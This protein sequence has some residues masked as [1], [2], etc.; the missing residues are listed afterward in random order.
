MEYVDV[1]DSSGHP[2]GSRKPKSEA[3]RDGDWHGAAHVW[4]LNKERQIL[5]QRRS[6]TKENYPNLW[7]V[8]V[9][10]HISAGETPVEA[11]LR[12]AQ[13]ELGVVL[14]PAECRYLFTIAEQVALNNG[15][16]LDNEYHHVFLVEKD[17]DV[18]DLKFSDGEVA[19]VKFV[20][21]EVLQTD[22]ATGPGSFVPHQEEYQKLFEV[23][24]TPAR[25]S[26][27]VK[28]ADAALPQD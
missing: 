6:P 3:H 28:S 15:S 13:E 7:D 8:S 18:R 9:A 27:S 23:L 26:S 12:E 19:E 14:V 25:E 16:Y 22:L 4:I 2:V 5:I 17:L 21:L 20:A 24:R 1:L 11:A 10:G